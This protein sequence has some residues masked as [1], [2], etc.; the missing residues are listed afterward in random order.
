[1]FSLV[2]RL[3]FLHMAEILGGLSTCPKGEVGVII[4]DTNGKSVSFGYNGA[5][6]GMKHC[7]EVGCKEI[8]NHCT[9]AVHAEINCILNG[10]IKRMIDGDI[11]IYGAS[12]CYR[13]AQAIITA[14][15]TD[16]YI[17]GQKGELSKSQRRGYD[18]LIQSHIR[19]EME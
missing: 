4:L 5:P 2:K 12:P 13:C 17:T 6:A 7:N 9:T 11:F 18:M 10:E 1:M 3:T 15:I 16:V 8:D 14:G 19:I